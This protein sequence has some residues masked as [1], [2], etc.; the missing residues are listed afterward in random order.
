MVGLVLGERVSKFQAWVGG[1][2]VGGMPV[3]TRREE[4]ALRLPPQRPRRTLRLE[5]S[6]RALPRHQQQAGIDIHTI[7]LR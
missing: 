4:E 2:V 7:P 3:T 1:R 5:T 6:R